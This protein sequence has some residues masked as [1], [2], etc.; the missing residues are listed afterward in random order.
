MSKHWIMVADKSKARIF[1]V[2]D[3]RGALLDEAVLEHPQAREREQALTSDRP[4]RSFDS[5][6][7]GR[8][9]MGTSVEP[10][11]QETIRFAKQIADHVQAAHN[12]GRCDRLLLVAGPP[13]LGLLR[14]PLNT[15]TGLR[16][17]EIE[18][19]LGQYDAREIRKHLP[20]R[21]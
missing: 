10:D 9:A 11:Q 8:H 18:K 5:K 19:N 20:E 2:A 3:P 12:E 16:I 4:G 21:L 7:Q 6:G 17:S 15:L 14:E 1:T 13:L